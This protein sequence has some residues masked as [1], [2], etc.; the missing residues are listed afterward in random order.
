MSSLVKLCRLAPALTDDEDS[1]LPPTAVE[2]ECR[3][4]ETDSACINEH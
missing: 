1:D 2:R 4:S 3:D